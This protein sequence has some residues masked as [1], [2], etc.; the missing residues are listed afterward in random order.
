MSLVS[1]YGMLPV[2]S[3]FFAGLV[4]IGSS[5]SIFGVELPRE[6]TAYWFDVVTFIVAIVI[7]RKLRLPVRERGPSRGTRMRDTVRELRE[8]II[9]V[10]HHRLVRAVV[11]CLPLGIGLGSAVV[12]LAPVLSRR[13]LDMGSSG[14]GL[15]IASL[16]VGA[17]LSVFV[18]S[19]FGG[20]RSNPLLF[21]AA[22]TGC[23]I[24][25]ASV[26][27]LATLP[28]A[29]V[30]MAATGLGAGL[31]YSTGFSIVQESV[32]DELRG[33]AFGV[34]SQALR[35]ALLGGLTLWPVVST[36]LQD[37]VGGRRFAIGDFGHTLD[38]ARVTLWLAGLAIFL[39][40]L[41]ATR[42]TR[43]AASD[44]DAQAVTGTGLAVRP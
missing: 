9:Y 33:R 8:G 44:E 31:V 29:M 41:L 13:V 32:P 39:V 1:I 24:A 40:G 42:L 2:G 18:A 26:A 22:L 35:L 14:F 6:T 12:P 25:V 23:G 7:L 19:A 15:L 36:V 17:G 5:F 37:E 34:L 28:T 27:V 38:G 4:T 20:R 21:S 10:V 11:L 16:G 30:G 3:A 43:R